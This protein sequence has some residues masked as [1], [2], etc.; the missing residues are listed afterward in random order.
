VIRVARVVGRRPERTRPPL[1][2][3]AEAS[4]QAGDVCPHQPQLRRGRLRVRHPHTA[5]A[6]QQ[7]GQHI[8]RLPLA[9]RG[10][11]GDPVDRRGPVLARRQSRDGEP[12]VL[13]RAPQHQ[14]PRSEVP[15]LRV[16]R[17]DDHGVVVHARA[18]VVHDP[19]ADR[20]A[21]CDGH[22]DLSVRLIR[23]V[24]DEGM[25][26]RVDAADGRRLQVPAGRRAGQVEP[27]R[28]EEAGHLERPVAVGHAARLRDGRDHA[29]WLKGGGC[30]IGVG[31]DGSNDDAR[32][33]RGHV[34]VLDDD[35]PADARSG[36]GAD[37]DLCRA[38]SRHRHEL[39]AELHRSRHPDEDIGRARTRERDA[40]RRGVHDV[41]AR[42]HEGELERAEGAEWYPPGGH[43]R[44]PRARADDERHR[45]P[46][47]LA[48]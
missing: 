40:G 12:A 2:R 33:G 15:A 45:A 17:K 34:V 20:P 42:C 25:F 39:H 23:G 6:G 36:R 18:A 7:A 21:A 8:R 4:G 13:V 27:E 28:A 11:A 32:A 26:G 38:G 30:P 37:G 47:R 1:V 16:R 41:V 24:E 19:S 31:R 14:V 48:G 29:A 43:D 9:E 5:G 10:V 46:G 22:Q 35:P 44:R 3:A